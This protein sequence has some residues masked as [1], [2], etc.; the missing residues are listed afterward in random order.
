MMATKI[1]FSHPYR[2]LF[3]GVWLLFAILLV[4]GFIQGQTVL[5]LGLGILCLFM[6]VY[7]FFS[8]TDIVVDMDQKPELHVFKRPISL[9]QRTLPLHKIETFT[10][11]ANRFV[12]D[13]ENEPFQYRR[14][15]PVSYEIEVVLKNG[16][17]GLLAEAHTEE[18]ALN[19]VAQLNKILADVPSSSD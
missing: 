1:T 9:R 11:T 18:D 2:L 13:E 6:A 16:R 10:T 4:T 8:Q 17:T 12:Q 5:I 14:T 7:S 19:A 15:R 3:C